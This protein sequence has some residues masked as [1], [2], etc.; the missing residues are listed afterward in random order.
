M[1]HQ[2]RNRHNLIISR[3]VLE[4]G[5]ADGVTFDTL[6]HE[7]RLDALAS[8]CKLRADLFLRSS[9]MY[10]LPFEM[11]IRHAKECAGIVPN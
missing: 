5:L 6:R 11:H 4:A 2:R 1:N 9:K 7:Y 8:T 10:R 3:S